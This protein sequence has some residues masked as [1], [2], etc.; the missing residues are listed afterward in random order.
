MWVARD[1]DDMLFLYKTKPKRD[2]IFEDWDMS[3]YGDCM[4]LNKKLFPKLK[5]EDEPIEVELKEAQK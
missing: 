4:K 3:L 5:W 2:N 1:K